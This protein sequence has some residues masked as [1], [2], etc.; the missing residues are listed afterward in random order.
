MAPSSPVEVLRTPPEGLARRQ[1][2]VAAQAGNA[3]GD[4]SKCHSRR[5]MTHNSPVQSLPPFNCLSISV[6][7][8]FLR[9]ALLYLRFFSLM[10]LS[11]NLLASSGLLRHDIFELTPQ[12]FYGSELVTNCNHALQIPV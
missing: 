12:S 9:G 10:T 11:L 2:N 7:S 6:V 3:A 1:Q 4:P 8:T 5:K